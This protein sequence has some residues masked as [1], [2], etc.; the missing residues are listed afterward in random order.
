M[1]MLLHGWSRTRCPLRRTNS[2]TVCRVAKRVVLGMN[3]WQNRVFVSKK[4]VDK[5]R[6]CASFRAFSTD[7]DGDDPRR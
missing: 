6:L 4:E 5:K 2:Q 7:R 1:T 3:S